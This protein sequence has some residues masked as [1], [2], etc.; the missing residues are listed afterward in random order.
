MLVARYDRT[1]ADAIA[2]A[3]LERLPDL[4]ADSVQSYGNVLP[5]IFKSLTAYDPRAIAP[6]LRALPDAARKPPPKRDTWTAA[7]IEAQFRLA[8]A[9]ILGFPSEV[10]RN[11]AIQFE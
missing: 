2:S 6:L 3:G 7:S 1:M 9:Q 5:T 11:E 4:L 10:R 8:A